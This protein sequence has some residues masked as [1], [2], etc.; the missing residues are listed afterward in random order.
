MPGTGEDAALPGRSLVGLAQREDP[1]R[2]AFNE[3][4]AFASIAAIFMAR[5]GRWKYVRYQDYRPQLYDLEADPGETPDL[6]RKGGHEADR[7]GPAPAAHDLRSGR[8][9]GPGI[10]RSGA[11]GRRARGTGGRAQDGQRSLRHRARRGA[12]DLAVSPHQ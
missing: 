5:F 11:A 1:E 9:H 12:A 3:Y 4:Q 6:A 8:G 10:R 2:T 7:R